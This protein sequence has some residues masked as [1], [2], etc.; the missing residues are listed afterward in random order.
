MI[1]YVGMAIVIP[2]VVVVWVVAAV[3]CRLAW[4]DFFN[5]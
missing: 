2:F 5:D 3:V 4:R 1:E